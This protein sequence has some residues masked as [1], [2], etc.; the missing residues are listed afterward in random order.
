MH[1]SVQVL[2]GVII[3]RSARVYMFVYMYE[4]R[5]GCVQACV[6]PARGPSAAAPPLFDACSSDSIVSVSK[7]L[8][9]ALF[10]HLFI[11]LMQRTNETREGGGLHKHRARVI[12]PLLS[13]SFHSLYSPFFSSLRPLHLPRSYLPPYFFDNPSEHCLHNYTQQ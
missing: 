7:D 1:L 2:L 3:Q 6:L 10:H 4:R 11:M 8:P 12:F 5:R 9:A 13:P